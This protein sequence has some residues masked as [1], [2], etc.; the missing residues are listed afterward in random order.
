MKVARLRKAYVAT[1]VGGCKPLAVGRAVVGE[2]GLARSAWKQEKSGPVPEG[3]LKPVVRRP[4]R[5]RGIGTPCA[6]LTGP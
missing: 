3:G 6:F 4:S 1:A 2:G 5:S